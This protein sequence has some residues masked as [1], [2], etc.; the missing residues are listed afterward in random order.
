VGGLAALAGAGVTLVLALG[1][2]DAEPAP[3]AVWP[4]AAPAVAGAAPGAWAPA[5]SATPAPPG[6]ASATP[7]PASAPGAADPAASSPAAPLTAVAPNPA[8]ASATQAAAAATAA[9]SRPL[10]VAPRLGRVELPPIGGIVD[11]RRR[12][13]AERA[14]AAASAAAD[15]ARSATT[16][17][18]T[19]GVPAAAP[20]AAASA[21]VF[22]LTTRLLRTRTES[23]QIAEA[24]SAL[25][26]VPGSTVQR[27][28]VLPVGDDF[29]VVA[30]PYP[31]RT[32][33]ERA[34]TAL[35]ARGHRLQVISF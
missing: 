27:V 3:V 29:R 34:Q 13:A 12:E 20:A 1:L 32:E 6:A 2:F 28:D 4:G 9:A 23:Q 14:A 21:P 17:P 26:V 8:P 25:L 35:Q 24:L 22:A 7:G 18:T 10:D 31:G 11:A 30:W 5:A 19:A 33:A 15:T 16:T